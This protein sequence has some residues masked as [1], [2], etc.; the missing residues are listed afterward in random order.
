MSQ[1]LK[2]LNDEGLIKLVCLESNP[3][4]A[5]LVKRHVTTFYYVAFKLVKSKE[6]AEDIVQE[7]FLKLWKSPQKFNEEKNAKFT[8]WFSRVVQNCAIDY[9]RKHKFETLSDEFDFED[10][11]KNQLELIEEKRE[12]Q[13]LE[14]ALDQLKSKEKQA[15]QLSFYENK[16]HQESA[17]IMGLSLLAFQSLLMRS[18]ESLR[19]ILKN[20]PQFYGRK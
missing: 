1:N 5:E 11:A 7:C 6:E 9:L 18:K 3:A 2:Q 20:D 13:G 14:S 15:I 16:K 8:T 17:Q 19:L 4:F 12:Q 10:D